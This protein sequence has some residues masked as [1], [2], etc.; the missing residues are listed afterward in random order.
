MLVEVV[1]VGT[2][3]LLGQILD[4]NSA[5]LADQLAKSGMNVHRHTKV[6]DNLERMTEVFGAALSRADAV[7]STGGLGPT[8]DDITREAIAEVTGRPLERRPELVHAVTE[9]FSR[10]GREMPLS[11]LRQADV[12][13]GGEVIPFRIG[14]APGLIVPGKEGSPAER[15]RLYALPGVSAEMKE[16][17]TRAVLP[18]LLAKMQSPLTIRSRELKCWVS[19]SLLAEMLAPR[20]AVHAGSS[21]VT[22][23]FLASEGHVRVRLTAREAPEV[24]D[25]LLDVEEAACREIL[26][27]LVF[28][29]DDDTLAK[30]CLDLLLAQGWTLGA[31]ES[32]TGGKVGEWITDVPGSSQAFLG[33][34]VSYSISAKTDILGVPSQ[35]LRDYGPVSDPVARAMAKGARA[36][37][38]ADVGVAVTGSAGPTPDDRS[39]VGDV[40]HAVDV[41][42]N[43]TVTH[44]HFNGERRLVKA[45][46]AASTLDLLR[47]CLSGMSV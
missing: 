12:P 44:S 1:T 34:V 22:I 38:G 27:D 2:E 18:D 25:S 43:V 24:V 23:A 29:C 45:F 30:V 35:V 37:F 32:V 16:M 31:A 20:F 42:G 15:K 33:S 5:W 41:Q 13:Q 36:C 4:T 46:A 3:L 47:R 28:G 9:L 8:Q 39:A 40:F 10:R 6:G 11:N 19:E 7:V 26:G 14:T 21:P 17:F